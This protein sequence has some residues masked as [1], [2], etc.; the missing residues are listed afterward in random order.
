MAHNTI[1]LFL[2]LKFSM[3]KCGGSWK[4]PDSADVYG[5]ELVFGSCST[6][7]CHLAQTAS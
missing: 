6:Q 5:H 7:Y 1:K 2:F 3:S 4:D